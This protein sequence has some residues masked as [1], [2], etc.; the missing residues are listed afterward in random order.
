MIISIIDSVPD[1]PV[2][3]R[4]KLDK[5]DDESKLLLIK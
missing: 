2:V 5:S 1:I 3:V 4:G